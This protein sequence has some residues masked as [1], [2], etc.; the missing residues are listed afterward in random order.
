[1]S[2]KC[3][4]DECKRIIIEASKAKDDIKMERSRCSRK[5][6]ELPVILLEWCPVSRWRE[7]NIGSYTERVNLDFYD[8]GN[9]QVEIP[10]GRIPMRNT[11]AEEPVVVMK[12]L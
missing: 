2:C 8:K 4:R 3:L 6:Q 9:V 5:V 11:G 1:M 10:R 7:L 12:S